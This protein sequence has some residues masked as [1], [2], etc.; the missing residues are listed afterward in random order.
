LFYFRKKLIP[1]EQ[2]TYLHGIT[3]AVSLKEGCIQKL[4][5]WHKKLKFTPNLTYVAEEGKP[6][7]V[8]KKGHRKVSSKA[9]TKRIRKIVAQAQEKDFSKRVTDPQSSIK[10]SGAGRKGRRKISSKTAATC[11]GKTVPRVQE[12]DV[13]KGVLDPHSSTKLSGVAIGGCQSQVHIEHMKVFESSHYFSPAD[14]NS[15]GSC[16]FSASCHFPPCMCNF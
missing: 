9:V 16:Q 4:V 11:I 5:G 6:P 12:E 10:P 13:S 3:V 2:S 7:S 1:V 14:S 8:G 15:I